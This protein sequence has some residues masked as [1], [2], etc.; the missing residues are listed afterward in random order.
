MS[1]KKISGS[2]AI[3]S[4]FKTSPMD[5]PAKDIVAVVK[6]DHNL[7]VTE[8]LVGNIRH[9][10]KTDA[11]SAAIEKNAEPKVRKRRVRVATV[12]PVVVQSEFDKL[13][14]VKDFAAKMGGVA[15][16]RD[17]LDKITRLAA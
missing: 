9:R 7:D 14:A 17:L 6:R 15:A 4:A 2:A 11:E 13:I 5:A 1:E 8:A 12:D 3:R 10:L 16:L